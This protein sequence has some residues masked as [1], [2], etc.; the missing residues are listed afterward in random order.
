MKSHDHHAMVQQILLVSV[1]NLLQVGLKKAIIRLRKSFQRICVKVL[2]LEDLVPLQTYVVEIIYL[3]E[4]WFPLGFF[5][6]MTHLIMHLVDE[7]EICGPIGDKWCYPM[8]K[9]LSVLKRYVRN[10]ARLEACMAFGFM[11]DEAL[12]FCTKYFALYPHTHRHMWDANEK[13]V[14]ISEVLERHVQFKRLNAMELEAIHEH[15]ITN[16]VAIDALYKYTFQS[17]TCWW[18]CGGFSIHRF[19]VEMT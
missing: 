10:K 8:E 12:G 9:Y 19:I 2:N 13:E 3:F 17:S 5:D 18:I 7:L 15:V 1:W 11:Y 4:I 16:S 6:M 14:D